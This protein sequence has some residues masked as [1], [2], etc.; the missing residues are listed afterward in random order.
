MKMWFWAFV[1][2][3]VATTESL[4]DIFIGGLKLSKKIQFTVQSVLSKFSGARQVVDEI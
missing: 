1:M 2:F 4:E 3:Q